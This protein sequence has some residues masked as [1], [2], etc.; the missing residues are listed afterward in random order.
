MLEP[1]AKNSEK[2]A[3]R[4][5][6][7]VEH[8]N[9]VIQ[10]EIRIFLRHSGLHTSEDSMRFFLS[11]AWLVAFLLDVFLMNPDQKKANINEA[12]KWINKCKNQEDIQHIINETALFEIVTGI[13]V[14]E[15]RDKCSVDECGQ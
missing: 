15:E 2:C 4:E 14:I 13:Q 9:E 12:E 10:H 11:V 8:S 7:K 3:Q 6:R 5:D 1:K